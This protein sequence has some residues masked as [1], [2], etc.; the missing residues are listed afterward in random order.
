MEKQFDTIV[1]GAGSG[2]LIAAKNST[3]LG[4][5][6]LLIEGAKMGGD[7]L[8]YGCVPSKALLKAAH[9]ANEMKYAGEFGISAEYKVDF[10]KVMQRVA[11][12]IEEI[13]PNDSVERYEGLGV[14]V[15]KGYGKLVS[16]HEVSVNGE[17]Y[18]ATNIVIATGSSAFIPP[19]NGLDKVEY[20]TNE[21]VF[22]LREKPNKM[23]I[24]GAGVIGL[25]LGQSFAQLGVDVS[26]IDRLPR[27]FPMEDVEVSDMMEKQLGQDMEL[28]LDANIIAVSQGEETVVSYEVASE[29]REIACDT[30]L[31]ALGRKGN[32]KGMGLEEIG[33]KTDRGFIVVDEYLRTSVENIYAVGDSTGRYLFTHAASYEAELLID[34]IYRNTNQKTDY[35]KMPWATFTS[36]EVAHV[37]PMFSELTA[38]HVFYELPIGKN[39]K[40]IA[41]NDRVGIVKV[42]CLNDRIV[43]ATVVGKNAGELIT[44]FSLMVAHGMSVL[45]VRKMIVQ[46]PVQSELVKSISSPRYNELLKEELSNAKG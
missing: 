27:I 34:N 9:L 26:V 28:I 17:I 21:S 3:R 24:L 38:E 43:A 12:V 19:I 11:D 37:G 25:E 31:V 39:D 10:E 36:P 18:R 33:V 23:V 5:K 4:K 40:S 45:D 1:I 7:C 35:S 20:L 41:I 13:A 15:I 16:G 6:T 42:A 29:R 32:T 22:E 44:T 2:G 46:Y 14:N 30:L 8:N